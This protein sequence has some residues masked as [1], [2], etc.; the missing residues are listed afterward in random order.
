MSIQ[1]DQKDEGFAALASSER[2]AATVFAEVR[3]DLRFRS[4]LQKRL[5]IPP[6]LVTVGILLIHRFFRFLL[7]DFD[8]GSFGSCGN[9]GERCE[10]Q[11]WMLFR[12]FWL[13]KCC[14]FIHLF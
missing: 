11:I 4:P 8:S 13:Y 7:D 5:T 2:E 12:F 3:A 9:E 6:C 1:R 10:N 14:E